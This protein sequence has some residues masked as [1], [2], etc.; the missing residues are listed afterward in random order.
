MYK[1]IQTMQG[2]NE[3]FENDE[4][5]DIVIKFE[6]KEKETESYYFD[7]EDYGE[8]IDYYVRNNSFDKAFDICKIAEKQ[9]P[10]NSSIMIRKAQILIENKK[11]GKGLEILDKV[12]NTAAYSLEIVMLRGIANVYINNVNK[13]IMYFDLAIQEV[14]KTNDEEYFLHDIALT[15]MQKEHYGIALRYLKKAYK[16][17]PTF[18]VI[19]YDIGFCL[20]KIDRDKESVRYLRK[21]LKEHPYSKIAWYN[22]GVVYK[23]LQK[24]DE[25][26]EAYDYAYAIDDNF[27]SPLYNKAYILIRQ[28]K[29]SEAIEVYHD[30]LKIEPDNYP[31]YCFIG[32]CYENLNDIESA[33][34]NYL[35]SLELNS[36]FADAWYGLGMLKVYKSRYKESLKFF[37]NAAKYD[38]T[39][40]GY[41]FTLAK[42]YNNL[43]KRPE[44]EML[45]KKTISVE[46]FNTDFW[47]AYAEFKFTSKKV[48]SAILILKEAKNYI[49]DDAII[50][51]K[52]AAYLFSAEKNTL[53]YR[54]LKQALKNDF[55][56]HKLFLEYYP[57]GKA[58][59]EIRGLIESYTFKKGKKKK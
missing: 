47:I 13:A 27:S 26:I 57:Q 18:S 30:F 34:K 50:D 35:K 53:A 39:N 40:S 23:K 11:P 8:I 54:F 58:N 17:N 42:V 46:P 24:F 56:A 48:K 4:K 52:L 36:E 3:K 28:K 29:Y 33:E 6:E 32:E 12:E 51:Y 41:W 21:F 22:L 20:E 31:V 44:A 5:P 10:E 7:V 45:F 19:A 16:I 43:N 2:N 49:P 9:H 55:K 25:A 1:T 15:F 38:K 37:Q 14:E 59:Q